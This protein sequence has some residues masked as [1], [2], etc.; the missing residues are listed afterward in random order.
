MSLLVVFARQFQFLLRGV[1]ISVLL[2][3][4]QADNRVCLPMLPHVHGTLCGTH[5]K[6]LAYHWLPFRSS[7][8]LFTCTSLSHRYKM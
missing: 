6:T 4:V 2:A 8:R 7:S 3:V 1:N 5:S